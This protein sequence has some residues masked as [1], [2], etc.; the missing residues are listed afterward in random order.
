M[1][2]LH[3]NTN[4]SRLHRD[5]ALA[6]RGYLFVLVVAATIPLIFLVPQPQFVRVIVRDLPSVASV[7]SI[8]SIE[9]AL[10]RGRSALSETD[11]GN[12]KAVNEVPEKIEMVVPRE[13]DLPISPVVDPTL[14]GLGDPMGDPRKMTPTQ[15]SVK[16]SRFVLPTPIEET[17]E[18]FEFAEIE[19]SFDLDALRNAI[20]YPEMARRNGIEGK[21]VVRALISATGVV[22]QAEIYASD[23]ILLEQEALRSTRAVVYT[24]AK[25]NGRAVRCWVFIPIDFTLR[26]R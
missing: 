18:V 17:N 7:V 3:L 11:N 19:P 13:I 8:E 6:V 15:P 20:R 10:A 24:P 26:S 25:Q 1:T 12:Y 5:D 9:A 4:A 2:S 22:E 21:V 23:H 16:N 14:I